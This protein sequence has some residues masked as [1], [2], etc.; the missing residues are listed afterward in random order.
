MLRD[1]Q[2]E[3]NTDEILFAS[4]I[5]NI[6][7][8]YLTYAYFTSR[9]LKTHLFTDLGQIVFMSCILAFLTPLHQSLTVSFSDD[10]I[11]V[12]VGILIC[13]HCLY[14]KYRIKNVTQSRVVS[15]PISL[16]AIF[17]ATIL[18]GSRLSRNSSVFVLLF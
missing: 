16:N 18:L 11:A 8:C 10:T 12:L 5:T 13:I 3:R 7:S 9:S 14:Y 6:I 1:E 15:S 4:S 17:F 2:Y